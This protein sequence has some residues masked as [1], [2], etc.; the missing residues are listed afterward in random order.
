MR[1]YRIQIKVKCNGE[2]ISNKLLIDRTINFQ[3]RIEE[4]HI[5]FF[6]MSVWEVKNWKRNKKETVE[7]KR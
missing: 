4:S 6:S 2:K 3:T 7:K 5:H 1:A